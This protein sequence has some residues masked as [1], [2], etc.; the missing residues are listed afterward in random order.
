MRL[1]GRARYLSTFQDGFS[2]FEDAAAAAGGYESADIAD[3]AEEAARAV[4]T[5]QAVFERDGVT[6]ADPDPRWPVVA[7][8]LLGRREGQPLRVLDVGGGLGSSYW[9]NRG[10]LEEGLLG[11]SLKWT[12]VEQ[13]S[14]V[15]RAGSLPPHDIRYVERTADEN[16]DQVDCV[17]LSSSLQYLPDPGH[18]LA[19]AAKTSARILVIDRTPM[20]RS[21][22]DIPC[23]QITPTH[24]YRASYPVWVFSEAHLEILLEDWTI[25]ARFPGIEPDMKTT[26][27]IPFSWRGLIAVRRA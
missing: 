11:Q 6:F 23:V 27:G 3:R 17:L 7:G 10:V 1:W 9:Q 8:L 22:A 4:L 25:I 13:S 16:P 14:M 26:S 15:E 18:T 12:V 2:S 5:G 24:I 20:S 21:E 19:E